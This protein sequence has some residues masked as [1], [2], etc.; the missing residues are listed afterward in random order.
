MKGWVNVETRRPPQQRSLTEQFTGLYCSC[1][2]GIYLFKLSGSGELSQGM[3][4]SRRLLPEDCLP[5]GVVVVMEYYLGHKS[6][7]LLAPAFSLQLGRDCRMQV[8]V[9]R[10]SNAQ[11]ERKQS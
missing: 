4:R 5:A 11:L 1:S 9:I 10:P 8:S 3:S 2:L 6:A 7:P